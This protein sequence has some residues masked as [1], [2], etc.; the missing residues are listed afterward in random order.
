MS[1]TAVLGAQW[2]DEGKGK[3]VHFLSQEADMAV[4]FNGGTNAGHTVVKEGEKFQL[5]LIPSG[6][7]EPRCRGVLG[8]GM[9]IDP[10]ALASEMKKLQEAKVNPKIFI[11]QGAHL[12]L[13][14]HPILEKLAGATDE[15]GTTGK[16]IGPSYKDKADRSGIKAIDLMEP[17]QLEA[18]ID[19]KLRKEK[20]LWGNKGELAEFNP[21]S[22]TEKLLS[23]AQNF[24]SEITN[25]PKLI[26]Q[27]IENGEKVLF[28]GAQGCLLDIDFG[29]YPFVTSSNTTI[30]GIGVGAG[31][32]PGKVKKV[33]GV[34]KA[35]TTRVGAGPFPT[36]ES[37]RIGKRLREKGDEYGTTTGRPRRCGWLDLVALKYASL[38][39][40]FTGLAVTKLDVLSGCEEI[41]VATGYQYNG[42]LTTDFPASPSIL[43]NCTPQYESFEGWDE[44]IT[45][46]RKIE[47]LPKNARTYLD[48]LTEKLDTPLS[49]VS[50]GPEFANTILVR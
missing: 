12:V 43:E 9:V 41:K 19:K 27:A 14:Y 16:G 4:R 46:C 21:K 5:H 45:D 30:G 18:K 26:N 7:L 49:I 6:T 3:V 36:E 29:T 22:L 42:E 17:D 38:V 31:V 32:N 35:Y 50:V 23:V 25:T 33:I 2:G 34:V 39:N 24:S 10:F 28:E 37:G 1:T 11:S 40:G 48:F 20:K 13:P 15:I 47:E 8:N 44:D